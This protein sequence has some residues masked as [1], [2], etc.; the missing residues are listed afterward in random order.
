MTD[1]VGGISCQEAWDKLSN[2]PTTTLVDVRTRAEWNF[3]GF[4]DLSSIGKAPL[5]VEWQEFPSTQPTPDFPGRL[6]EA[7]SA[8]NLPC[9]GTCNLLF[10]CRSGG[11][12]GRAAEA[13]AEAELGHCF[14]LIEGFEGGLNAS[15]HR[16]SLEGWRVGGFPW[17]QK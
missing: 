13:T 5:F 4:A 6:R 17:R 1:S 11:R 8:A 9:D 7:L 10:M 15:G 3:V 16:N 12:S 2:E 14:N